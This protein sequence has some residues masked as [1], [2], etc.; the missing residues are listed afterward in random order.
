MTLLQG[1]SG[2]SRRAET[3]PVSEINTRANLET[4]IDHFK[5]FLKS[6]QILMAAYLKGKIK[7]SRDCYGEF[8]T[9]PG[10]VE[11]VEAETNTRANSKTNTNDHKHFR[12]LYQLN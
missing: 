2:V 7:A 4:N 1:D 5:P 10:Y 3:H 11:K 8:L 12:F 9:W 6:L